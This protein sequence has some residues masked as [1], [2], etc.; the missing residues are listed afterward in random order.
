MSLSLQRHK[1]FKKDILKVKLTD[2]QYA[3]FIRFVALAMEGESLPAESKDHALTGKW[4]GCRELYLG[5]DML[6]IY[7]VTE[8]SI[9][10]IRIGSHSQLFN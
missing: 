1:Q 4:K 2:T 8:N 5:G 3:K 7:T 6:L 9:I 10:L